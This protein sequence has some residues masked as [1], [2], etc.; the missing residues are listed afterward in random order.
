MELATRVTAADTAAAN[1]ALANLAAPLDALL[2]DATLG[3]LGGSCPNGST[4]R[5]AGRLA[6]QP[7]TTARRRGRA[8]RGAG[9]HRRRHRRRS[10]RRPRDRRFADP[11][12][13]GNPV[14]RR[15]VQAYLA[16]GATVEQLVGDADLAWRDDQRV[17]FLAGQPH[18][19]AGAEQRRRCSTRRRPRPRS[20]AAALNFVRGGRAFLRD[21]APRRASRRWSTRRAVRGR[22][23]PRGDAGRGRAAHRGVRADPVRAAAPSTVR[24]VPLLLVPPTINKFYVLDLAPGPQPG[25]STSCRP[26]SRCSSCPGAT[27]T[28]GTPTGASTPTSRPCS[29]RSTPSSAIT[30]QR[31]DRPRRDLLRRHPR[32][33]RRRAPGRRPA[34]QDR[35]AGA[36]VPGGHGARPPPGRR[37]R[38]RSPTGGLA[39]AATALSRRRGYLDGRAL[40][41]VFAWLRPG[42]LVWNYWVNNYLLG[43]KPPAFDILFWNADTTRMTA[44]LHADFVDLAMDNSLVTPGSCEVLG[45]PIDLRRS[46]STLRR[47]RA[48][49]TTSR[50]G[51]AATAPPT[52]SAATPGSCCRPAATSP[53][54]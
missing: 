51:R 34:R 17:R 21:M 26:G 37:R 11:A 50:P 32:Q 20:T 22:R 47:R 23:E 39:A 8:G 14:L 25:S 38:P 7:A 29:T 33:H 35:L 36:G 15:I 42:D 12:W 4:A 9:P 48:S 54:W 5:L 44:R 10:H 1:Q 13:A 19:G 45:T 46:T 53:R 41:E 43:R 3:P 2:V 28:P 52:C 30:P 16:T 40:A 31:D 49:P 27:P 6:A 24:E 18:R